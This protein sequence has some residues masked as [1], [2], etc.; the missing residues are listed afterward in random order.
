[1]PP[2]QDLFIPD[3]LEEG[4]DSVYLGPSK[5]CRVFTI[6]KWPRDTHVGWLDEIFSIGNIDLSLHVRPIPDRKV[7]TKLTDEIVSAKS[8]WIVEKRRG[9]ETRLPELEG[10]IRDLQIIREA[11]QANRDRMFHATLL[12]NVHG[13]DE[14][15]LGAR[16][17]K[18]D[19]VMA[20]QAAEIRP[21]TFRQ[22]DAL[23]S[24]IPAGNLAIHGSGT[25]RNLTLG[26]TATV[27]PV[28]SAVLSHP[29]GAFLGFTIPANN[30]VFI[31]PF[32][33]PP[34]LPNPHM[35]VFGY[36]GA[37]KSVTLKLLTGRLSLLGVRS[38]IFDLEG[39]YRK[40]SRHLYDGGIIT[41][42]PGTPAGMNPL[43]LEPEFDR[44]TKIKR[45][46]I[47]D[48]VADVR[49]LVSTAV[50]G[51]AGRAL[52]PVETALLEEA[53]RE[54]YAERGI[55]ADPASLYEPG[56]KKLDGGGYAVGNVKKRMPTLSDLHAKLSAKNGTEN[57]CVILKPF[58]RENSLGMFDCETTVDLDTRVV[59]FDFSGV[60]D[61]FTK[62]YAMFVVLSW[63]WHKFALRHEGNKMVVVDE[64]WMFAKW[65]ESARFLETLARRGRKHHTGLVVASQHIEEFIS[66]EEGRAVISSCAT[67]VL[68]GQNPTV[69]EEVAR[70]FNLP[71]GMGERL[72]SFTEGRCILTMGQ[73]MAEVQVT[74]LPY[75]APYVRTG[76]GG[77]YAQ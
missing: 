41:V 17:D 24:V 44:E 67:R 60:K 74:E 73:S 31:D 10:V 13:T 54:L 56:G 68:L 43:E 29:R 57:L 48:K 62:L 72:Q 77:D 1:V 28:T 12:I 36:T 69:A 32:I 50:R 25:F 16:C 70:A 39:E 66:R 75:E 63:A 49:A 7:T 76:G 45:V 22:L 14:D 46:N 19:S 51:Y 42:E 2:V 61:E 11:I 71:A 37:G 40:A 26:G 30:P 23:K 18:L 52:D 15:D 8:Q 35:A 20:R 6:S 9:S 58:L 3:G 65:P 55:T 59:T 34:W 27:L 47:S 21:L 64:A 5:L 4:R 38:I 33:G 53:V